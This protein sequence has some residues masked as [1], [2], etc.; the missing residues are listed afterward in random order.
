MVAEF[1]QPRMALKMPQPPLD[2]SSGLQQ[3]TCLKLTPQSIVEVFR[4]MNVDGGV[5][6]YGYADVVGSWAIPLE[7]VVTANYFFPLIV[8]EEPDCF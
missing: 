3:L 4:G 6:P 1:S 8:V 7:F 2:L 5:V